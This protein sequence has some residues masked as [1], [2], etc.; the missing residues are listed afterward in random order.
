MLGFAYKKVSK[1]KE[2]INTINIFP[3]PDQDT[4][5]NLV[6][7]L[8]GV[9]E[10]IVSKNFTTMRQMAVSAI[11]G[12]MTQSAG[13]V[14]IIITGFLNGF[15]TTIYNHEEV[16]PAGLSYAF[17]VGS[18]YAYNSIQDPKEGTILDVIEAA[19]AGSKKN[20]NKTSSI[21]NLLQSAIL[22]AKKALDDTRNKMEIYRKATV[23]DAGG[24]GF[25]L[26]MEGFLA[27]LENKD[28]QDEV[29]ERKATIKPAQFVQKIGLRFEVV[30]LLENAKME[31]KKISQK[32][33]SYGDSIDIVTANK[34]TKIHIHTNYP[35]EVTEI[36]SRLGSVIYMRTCDMTKGKDKEIIAQKNNIGL[37]VDGAA[38]LST[39]YLRQHDIIC[40]S[41]TTSWEKVDAEEDFK[42][43]NIYQKIRKVGHRTKEYGWPKTSQPS[44]HAFFSSFKKQL[45]KYQDII[46]ITISSGLSGSYNSARQARK[47]LKEYEK[48]HVIISDYK[49]AAAGQ[50]FL[51][52]RAVELIG[53]HYN[54][55]QIE[56]YLVELAN[57]IYLFGIPDDIN[58]LIRGGR[59]TG[60]KAFVTRTLQSLGIVAILA[61]DNGKII[62]KKF[63]L[64]KRSMADLVASQLSQLQL[65][66]KDKPLEIIVQHADCQGQLIKLKNQL[67]KNNFKLIESDILSP[68]LGLHTGPDAFIVAVINSA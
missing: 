18:R 40:V 42:N 3:V 27:G 39:N 5:D 44:P 22:S 37:V 67:N 33:L 20:K 47:M 23:V 62:F 50:V 26:M 64:R 34:K 13:N 12:A 56:K 58:W 68:V 29:V 15:L 65:R 57:S 7:T 8:K 41:F 10:A 21:E 45:G 38:G 55:N 2:R 6:K 63:A 46:C 53:R 16:S 66:N 61:L 31:T 30:A 32:L 60:K 48:K 14:G 52:M 51:A 9:H 35:D 28:I 17:F 4:G 1:H 43:L 19:A 24:Y 49:Q 54:I 59:L 25:L 36:I 11:D